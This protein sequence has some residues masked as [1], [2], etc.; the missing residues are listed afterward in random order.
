MGNCTDLVRTQANQ[1]PSQNCLK[2]NKR[3]LVD[4]FP[5]A[6]CLD[7]NRRHVDLSPALVELFLVLLD[8]LVSGKLSLGLWENFLVSLEPLKLRPLEL[9][10]SRWWEGSSRGKVFSW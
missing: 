10:S 8:P 6:G 4:L 3:H 1:V 5:A 2:V 7:Q 9:D